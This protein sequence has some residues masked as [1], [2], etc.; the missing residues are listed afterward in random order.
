MHRRRDAASR[1]RSDSCRNRWRDRSLQAQVCRRRHAQD[2]YTSGGFV[3]FGTVVEPLSS[4]RLPNHLFSS[5][6]LYYRL[7]RC[8]TL[9]SPLIV[10]P[11]PAA[12]TTNLTRHARLAWAANDRN[13]AL[14]GFDDL[15]TMSGMPPQPV[16]PPPHRCSYRFATSG[17]ALLQHVHDPGILFSPSEMSLPSNCRPPSWRL[18]AREPAR[19]K[20]WE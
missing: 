6:T 1:P 4:S 13:V 20:G 3:T 11:P 8:A 14:T 17:L 2:C 19:T 16:I 10:P 9:S 18:R 7:T 5:S 12:V 15:D